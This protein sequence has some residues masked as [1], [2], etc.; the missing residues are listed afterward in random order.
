MLIANFIFVGAFILARRA[1]IA[2]SFLSL[3]SIVVGGFTNMFLGV[4]MS[5]LVLR[6]RSEIFD[7]PIRL[8]TYASY[9][10]I[11]LFL[12]YVGMH[13]LY[14]VVLAAVLVLIVRPLEVWIFFRGLN[15]VEKIHMALAEQKGITTILLLLMIQPQ[16]DI[17][18]IVVPA[19]IAINVYF[20]GAHSLLHAFSRTPA[21][22]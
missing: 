16:V 20:V 2:S 18:G 7:E 1:K 21:R 9:L 17:I 8:I 11:G 15:P 13:I 12:P 22:A 14:G 10:I 3:T 19:M 4:A 6:M 5:G